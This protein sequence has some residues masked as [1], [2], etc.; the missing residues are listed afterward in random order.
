M[1]LFYVGGRIESLI[2]HYNIRGSSIV[3]RGVVV[4]G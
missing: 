4:E 3:C 1:E 2:I